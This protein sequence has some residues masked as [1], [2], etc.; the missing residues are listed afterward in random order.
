G[1]VEL[2][3]LAA[4][5][6]ENYDAPS[7]ETGLRDPLT[8]PPRQ[9][10]L[11]AHYREGLQIAGRIHEL[12]A[13]RLVVEKNGEETPLD[14]HDIYILLRNRTHA[15]EY[16]QA[17][18]DCNIPYVGLERGGLLESLEVQDLEALLNVLVTPFNNLAL[19]QVLKSPLFCADD[20]DLIQLAGCDAS[21]HWYERLT[22]LVDGGQASPSLRRACR[23]LAE[24]RKLVGR[25]PVH[26]LLDRIY[27]EGDVLTRYRHASPA[28]LQGRVHAN[29]NLLLEMAL[30]I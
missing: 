16:E 6:A 13:E 9:A 20:R 3:P 14:L 25:L 8:E 24:W 5:E 15:A 12:I 19:A 27:H 2:L 17:L 30:E 11:S 4:P 7:A 10:D 29:L 23:L 1:R 26:D 21:I 22:T 28:V 18:Q